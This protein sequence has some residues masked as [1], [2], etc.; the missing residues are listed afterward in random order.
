MAWYMLPLHP[1]A[2]RRGASEWAH[3]AYPQTSRAPFLHTD[4][5]FQS[6]RKYVFIYTSILLIKR[7]HGMAVIAAIGE[8]IIP[9]V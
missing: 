6:Q 5:I 3:F 2:P 9:E 4:L 7:P 8:V 1:Y